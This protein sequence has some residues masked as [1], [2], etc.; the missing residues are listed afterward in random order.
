[1]KRILFILLG[2][3][4]FTS[5]SAQNSKDSWEKAISLFESN[6]WTVTLTQWKKSSMQTYRDM[7]TDQNYI[8]CNGGQVVRM[9]NVA[10]A[11]MVDS[12]PQKDIEKE[13]SKGSSPASMAWASDS[14]NIERIGGQ[15]LTFKLRNSTVIPRKKYIEVNL[16]L[17]DEA[18]ITKKN[19]LKV[20]PEKRQ[21]TYGAFIGKY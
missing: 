15:Q 19:V 20:Y 16:M 6:E 3:F 18:G 2:C 12:R 11:T 14:R 1:M 8:K 4:I 21:V 5:L 13:R 9:V 17:E 7:V 10:G